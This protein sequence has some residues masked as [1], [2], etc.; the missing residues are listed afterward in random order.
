LTGATWLEGKDPAAHLA[1][2]GWPMQAR[3]ALDFADQEATRR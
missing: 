3:E 2:D 1:A